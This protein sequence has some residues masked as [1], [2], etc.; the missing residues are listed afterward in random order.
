MTPG[1]I[2]KE[3][4]RLEGE[5]KELEVEYNQYFAGRLPKPP[6][7]TRKRVDALAKKLDR[8][9]MNN[10]GMRFRFL[11]IQTRY[12]RFID[13]WDRGLRAREEGR[14]G[15]FFV[16]A[17]KER[18]PPAREPGTKVLHVTAFNDPVHEM[19]KLEELYESLS[20]ARRETGA[21]PVPFHKFASLVKTQVEKMKATGSPEVAFRVAVSDGKVNFTARALKGASGQEPDTPRRRKPDSE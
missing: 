7:D 16:P 18:T 5:L 20:N 3:L 9:H 10:T 11:T 15:P 4:T 6:W 14:P 12:A 2:D 17:P 19:R 8:T 1:E 21:P 13:L